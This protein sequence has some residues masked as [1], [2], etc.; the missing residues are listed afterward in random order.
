VPSWSRLSC[1]PL[2]AWHKRKAPRL[3]EPTASSAANRLRADGWSIIAAIFDPPR[4][5]ID[6]MRQRMVSALD[7]LHQSL[8]FGL[9]CGETIPRSLV[10][11]I[12]QPHTINP[13]RG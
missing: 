7:Q 3:G 10:G 12:G 5:L 4:V 1:G 8:S 6:A 11:G 9:D 2:S 13:T